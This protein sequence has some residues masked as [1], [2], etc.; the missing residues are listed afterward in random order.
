MST[1]HGLSWGNVGRAF[2]PAFCSVCSI[3]HTQHSVGRGPILGR[4]E[5]LPHTDGSHNLGSF[6]LSESY[7]SGI[8]YPPALRESHG[9]W[10]RAGLPYQNPTAVGFGLVYL[11]RSQRQLV[12]GWFT[13][14]EA[15]RRWF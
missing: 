12:L 3:P 5:S 10:V 11:I 6:G 1:C 13:L 7:P 4:L 2:Q 14:S 9:S 15:H 8:M